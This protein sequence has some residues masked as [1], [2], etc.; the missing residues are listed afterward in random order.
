MRVRA[1]ICGITRLVDAQAA[2]MAGCD[3]LGFNFHPASPRF[4]SP[5]N[6]RAIIAAIP[7]F[8]TCVGLFVDA[9]TARV[10]E[11]AAASGVGLLQ[12]HGDESDS[13][14]AA[15]G[16]PFIKVVPVS[17]PIDAMELERRFPR[18]SAL[19]FDSVAAG[20]TGGTGKTFDWAW[21]PRTSSKPLILAGGLNPNNVAEAIAHT[22]PFAVDVSSGV[23]GALKG[24]KD[25]EKL[26]QF[27]T[28]VQRA[29]RRN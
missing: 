7:P 17:G 9:Q 3:A 20:R 29:Q 28:E 16:Y 12:F 22:R 24:T 2:I 6:A 11:M 21:W 19:L 10:R 8:V 1:K 13:D 15:A 14:C 5:E 27:M 25:A 18:A 4:V 26:N 23:E